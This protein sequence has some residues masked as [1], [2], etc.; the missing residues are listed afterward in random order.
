MNVAKKKKKDEQNVH[1]GDFFFKEEGETKWKLYPSQPEAYSPGDSSRE[2]R[3]LF[4]RGDGDWSTCDSDKGYLVE[5]FCCS[6]G[7]ETLVAGLSAFL[8]VGTCENTEFIPF[9][10]GISRSLRA[11]SVSFPRAPSASS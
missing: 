5:G 9:S 11:S 1:P 10:P 2:L 4:H 3:E 8:S 7:T 6:Q